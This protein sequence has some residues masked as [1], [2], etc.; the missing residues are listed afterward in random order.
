MV[1]YDSLSQR[2]YIPFTTIGTGIDMARRTLASI[3]SFVAALVVVA[4]GC[5][6]A[7]DLYPTGL[8]LSSS[9]SNATF[10]P[11]GVNKSVVIDLPANIKDVLVAD[12]ATVSVVVQTKRRV[13]IIG[14]ALGQTNIYFYGAD[15]QQIS[16][17][18]IAVVT[19]TP[20]PPAESNPTAAPAIVVV[21]YRGSSG[22]TYSCTQTACIGAEKP[23]TTQ[24]SQ[25]TTVSR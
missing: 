8:R 10:M 16:A 13:Y 12:P 6:S 1:R 18:D 24:Y 7:A 17:L 15:G 21:V 19:G 25:I 23:D 4:S 22:A 2:G 14:K 3:A 5:A 20:L 9:D 11:L